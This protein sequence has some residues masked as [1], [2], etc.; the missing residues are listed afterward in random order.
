ME[1]NRLNGKARKGPDVTLS[2]SCIW[3]LE[4]LPPSGL[5]TNEHSPRHSPFWRLAGPQ[6]MVRSQNSAHRCPH[7]ALCLAQPIRCSL[8]EL[9]GGLLTAGESAVDSGAHGE[10]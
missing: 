8:G 5:G 9:R 1:G 4:A 7:G 2:Q 6:D 3:N 10:C